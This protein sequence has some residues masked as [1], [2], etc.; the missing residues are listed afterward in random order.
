MAGECRIGLV[1]AGAV[2]AGAYT[3]GVIDFLIQ[4]LEQWELARVG[5]PANTPPH[6]VVI[7]VLSGA[8]AG[9]MTAAMLA[10]ILA[11]R[12]HRP[13]TGGDPGTQVADNVLFQSWV[14]AID[15]RA[16]L[17]TGDLADTKA[18]L[19][20]LLDSSALDA[21]AERALPLNAAGTRRVYADENLELLLTLGNLRGVPYNLPFADDG[22]DGI[23]PDRPGHGLRQH[24]DYLHFRFG[25]LPEHA[26]PLDWSMQTAAWRLLRQG[27]LATG[28]FPLGLAARRIAQAGAVYDARRF[29]APGLGKL[30]DG[31]CD[32]PQPMQIK[33]AWG[34][35]TQAP[36]DY[37]FI[38]VDGG[39]FNNEPFELARDRLAHGGR[40]PR[41]PAI[42]DR[43]MLAIDPFPDVA[44]FATETYDAP[45][46]MFDVGKALIAAMIHQGRFKPGELV[47]AT[48]DLSASRRLISPSRP[49]AALG[50]TP[51]ASG[52]LGGFAGFIDRRFRLHDFMLGR[53][54]C[55]TFLRSHLQLPPNNPIFADWTAAQ[56]AAHARANGQCPVIPLL[57]TAATAAATLPWPV[58]AASEL[59]DLQKRLKQRLSALLPH[60]FGLI[61][62]KRGI[63]RS[64]A[65][66]VARLTQVGGWAADVRELV[67]QE[68]RKAGLIAPP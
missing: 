23:A 58:L 1:M 45:A 31:H 66:T 68:L 64:L 38:S 47:L 54:N 22:A 4:A 32:C 5:D 52:P 44:N 24:Q 27:A 7:S 16:L 56:R 33:P 63:M 48:R 37:A 43:I 60:A 6:R 28:A 57:G 9:G 62:R 39:V 12:A 65:T 42:A 61:F 18:P 36:A 53:A 49:G 41:D 50:D 30:P 8:S 15:I 17:G 25:A 46:G 20:S 21:I 11:G 10:G 34:D 2:S 29:D 13:I 40:N 55:Q 67:E 26:S 59:D 14:N 51:I 3:A 19:Q 35:T